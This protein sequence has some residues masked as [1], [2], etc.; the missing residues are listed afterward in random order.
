MLAIIFFTAIVLAYLLITCRVEADHLPGGA[1]L[2]FPFGDGLYEVVL[3]GTTLAAMTDAKVYDAWTAPFDC[4]VEKV[5]LTTAKDNATAGCKE[6]HIFTKD[7]TQDIV[8][9]QADVADGV[10]VDQTLASGAAAYPIDAGDEIHLQL[11]A[12]TAKSGSA[13][14][15]I[16]V[17]P[18]GL[19]GLRTT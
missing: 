10:N 2:P 7:A 19:K 3:R 13:V 12:D 6:V 17:R 8:A 18:I 4:K 9:T 16:F 1:V 15:R 5:L 14:A 11:D